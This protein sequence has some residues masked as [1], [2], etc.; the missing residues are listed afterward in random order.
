M[1]LMARE[2]DPLQLEREQLRVEIRAEVADLHR[3]TRR[4]G[5]EAE[6]LPLRIGEAITRAWK[7]VMASSSTWSW[8]SSFDRKW[9][10][11]PLFDM[12]T[13]VASRPSVSP[14]SP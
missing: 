6:P 5:E 14:P 4:V 12:R 9:A 3:E 2:D 7:R 13:S 10:K 8:S 1:Q 11:R